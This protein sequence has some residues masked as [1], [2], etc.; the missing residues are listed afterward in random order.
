M[1]LS[2]ATKL[3]PRDGIEP[4]TSALTVHGSTA[5][6]SRNKLNNRLA[7]RADCPSYRTN[8]LSCTPEPGDNTQEEVSSTSERVH[9]PAYSKAEAV[10]TR[11][12]A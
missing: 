6:L 3:A 7:R 9:T 2:I 1:L 8:T 4:P 11:E 5:E 10:H 12:A